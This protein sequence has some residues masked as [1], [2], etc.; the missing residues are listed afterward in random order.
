MES[1]I[2]STIAMLAV[3]NPVV[4]GAMMIQFRKGKTKRSNILASIASMSIVLFI[5][6]LSALSGQFVLA[7]LGIPMHI[8]VII[9]GFV[10]V[11]IGYQITNGYQQNNASRIKNGLIKLIVFAASPGSIAM[12]ITLAIDYNDEGLPV[13]AL[14]GSFLAIIISLV[15]MIAMLL[16]VNPQ[17]AFN[18]S[19]LF[20]GFV[21][22]FI[23]A[24]GLQFL[25]DG[26]K[27]FLGF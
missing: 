1:Y 15:I 11:L 21:G 27:Q 25:L 3:I 18:R 26:F 22:V 16:L 12:V 4:C 14:L 24:L 17:K 13:V 6:I 9:G 7:V 23:I 20:S 10:V 5:F 8:L 2:H 19:S